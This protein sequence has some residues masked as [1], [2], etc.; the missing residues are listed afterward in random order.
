M[1]SIKEEEF[2]LIVV[3]GGTAGLRTALYAA[4]NNYKTALIDPGILGGTCLNTGCIPTKS[5]LHAANL[6]K[7]IVSSKEFGINTEG[8]SIDF[9][10]VMRRVQKIIKIGQEHISKSLQNTNLEIIKEKASFLSKNSVQAGAKVLRGEKIIICTG[11]KPRIPSLKGIE[12]VDYLLSDDVLNLDK[13][14]ASII[15][16][17]GGYI[18][19]EFATFF[20]ALGSK[21]TIIERNPRIL[22]DLDEEVTETINKYYTEIGI[23]IKTNSEVIE[24]KEERGIK[25]FYSTLGEDKIQTVVAEELLVAVGRSPFIFGLNLEAAGIKIGNKGN[26][27]VNKYLQTS[28][29]KIYAIGDVN[30]KAP[31]AHAAKRESHV[32][33]VNALEN[34]KEMFNADLV[35]WAVFSDP[36]IAG[37]GL[38]EREARER[39][40]KYKILKAYFARAGRA[41][42]IGDTRG[43]VKVLYENKSK[44]I[45]GAIIIGPGADDIIH[46]FVALMNAHAT[47]DLLRK[48]IHIHPTL[49]EVFEALK[50]ISL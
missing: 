26:I 7:K 41:T 39:Q 37:I 47:V 21:V 19:I 40:I 38:N 11:A 10:A 49:S 27:E 35:P 48:V 25:V 29:P 46:E 23:L 24:V 20:S 9:K 12:K 14:P 5:M 17:G 32:A 6:Y 43:F 44:K 2:D 42:V 34:K 15:I 33:L 30:G 22:K 3:G 31:F 1:T 13:M 36:P 4:S 50:D 16:I 8:V 18:A 45:L 28:N